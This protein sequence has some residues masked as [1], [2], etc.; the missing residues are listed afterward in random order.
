MAIVKPNYNESPGSTLNCC[1]M[2]DRVDD[3]AGRCDAQGT[4]VISNP[5]VT[6]AGSLTLTYGAGSVA[7]G[8]VIYSFSGS[9]IN[10]VTNA[11]LLDRRDVL[12]YRVGTGIMILEGTPGSY[13]P[14]G[15]VFSASTSSGQ[16]PLKTD[17][18]ESTDCVLR[19]IVM[20]YNASTVGSSPSTTVGFVVDKSNQLSQ[21]QINAMVGTPVYLAS[22]FR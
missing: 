3:F 15:A 9:T 17:I 16:C 10:V 8:N 11:T 13:T 12:I 2:P 4:G 21:A 7:V 20:P 6:T 1:A 19:E 5:S 18:T 22:T 14:T